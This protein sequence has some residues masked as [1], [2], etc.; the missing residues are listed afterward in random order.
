MKPFLFLVCRPGGT[1]ADRELS[2]IRAFGRL[3]ERDLDV[4]HLDK[5]GPRPVLDDY[6]GVMISGSPCNIMTAPEAKPPTQVM[7]EEALTYI[8]DEILERDFPTLGLCFGMQ[9]LSQ[10]AGGTL[11]RD[12]PEIISAPYI[13]LTDEGKADPLLRGISDPFRAYTGHNEAVGVAPANAT[14]IAYSDLAPIQ[15]IRFGKNMYGTQFHPE[16]GL[17]SIQIRIEF[18]RGAYFPLTST[19]RS[20]RSACPHTLTTLLFPGSST[21]IGANHGFREV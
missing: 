3:R 1:V 11:T 10:R 7:T 14:V 2:D 17:E 5:P 12:F 4:V 19:N 21:R 18:Y 13:S 16:V 8:C 6:S 20:S 9:M 15:M